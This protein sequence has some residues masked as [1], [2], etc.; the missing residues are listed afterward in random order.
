MSSED[1]YARL[2]GYF[3]RLGY[4]VSRREVGG[5]DTVVVASKPEVASGITVYQR[6]VQ[7]HQGRDEQW[8]TSLGMITLPWNQPLED[9]RGFVCELME[10]DDGAYFEEQR[11][12]ARGVSGVA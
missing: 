6:S 10:S 3:R 9:L 11:R 7:L 2:V 12:R 8:Y 1:E 4:H 5:A